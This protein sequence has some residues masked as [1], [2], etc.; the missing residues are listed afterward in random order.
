MARMT[1]SSRDPASQP[2]NRPWAA[3]LAAWSPGVP[4]A[5]VPFDPGE[6]SRSSQY[7]ESA[8]W[9][10]FAAG[11]GS[12]SGGCR[13]PAP[14][15]VVPRPAAGAAWPGGSPAGAAWPGGPAGLA[16]PGAPSRLDPSDMV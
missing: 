11:G 13:A 15:G 5:E 16:V 14:P 8:G 3:G 6:R 9:G 7:D 12:S 10:G 1:T 2:P 4:F